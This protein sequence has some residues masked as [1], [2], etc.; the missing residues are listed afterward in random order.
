LAGLLL[1]G[2]AAAAAAA[3]GALGGFG[4]LSGHLERFR[5]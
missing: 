1:N 2:L 4:V 3:S 5:E